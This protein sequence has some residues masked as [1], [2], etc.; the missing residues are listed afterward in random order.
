MV[1]RLKQKKIEEVLEKYKGSLNGIDDLT[2]GKDPSLLFYFLIDAFGYLLEN[3]VENTVS[4]RGIINRRKFN[5]LIK[6]F[7]P[8]F[9]GNPQV[10]E[11]RN[12]LR[13]PYAIDSSQVADDPGIILPDEPVIW[14]ANHAF[15]DDTLAS[16]I[17]IYR[18][19]YILFGSLPQFYNTIDGILAWV[20]GVTMVNRKNKNSRHSSVGKA[21]KAIELG[22][23]LFE[24][25]EGVLN[26]T[27]NQLL[28]DLWPG[29]YKISKETGKM[30]VPMAHYI[31]ECSKTKIPNNEIHTVI[32]DPIRI[33]DLSEKA[34]LQYLRDAIAT[35][36]YLM[37]EKYGKST[38]EQ[39]LKGFNNSTEAW[40]SH[41]KERVATAS[42]YDKE[43]ELCAD[44]RPKDKI[45]P[46]DV[47]ESIA[48][49][50]LDDEYNDIKKLV[51]AAKREDFQRRF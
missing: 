35:N 4:Q 11:N 13:D 16:I 30:V 40:E 38:Y 7:G 36:Y 9:L 34:G 2:A 1:D 15:K 3:D 42:Y 14:T 33:D 32:D 20:V 41:L 12:F 19:A 27:P 21:I 17:A 37:M 26:K 39:E 10:I 46:E 51:K 44:Y 48:N 6:K 31:R 23:D 43:I 22:A 8:N 24:F 5:F 25:P 47:W 28:I 18:H 49:L 50:H 29:I 45:R